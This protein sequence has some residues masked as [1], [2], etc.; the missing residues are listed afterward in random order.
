[1]MGVL[2]NWVI[3]DYAEQDAF[4]IKEDHASENNRKY[5]VLLT[6]FIGTV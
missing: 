5:T 4:H 2:S 3:F 6:R 1:M